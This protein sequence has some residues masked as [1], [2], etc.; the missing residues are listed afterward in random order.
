ML[1]KVEGGKLA[2]PS[3]IFG[4]VHL[5][6]G[7]LA[8]LH[9]AV[10]TAFGEADV[11][12]T[13]IPMDAKSQ[14][15]GTMK[16]LRKD[17]KKLSDS[18]GPD[19]S[20]QFDAELSQINPQLDST[21]FQLLKT[22]VAAISLELIEAQMKGETAMDQ[23]LWQRAEKEGKKTDAIETLDSQLGVF[24]S[25]N[26]EEQ[27]EFLAE[28]LKMAREDREAGKDSTQELVDI[29]IKGDA[30][31]LKKEMDRQM[32]IMAKGEHKELGERLMKKI[33][34]DRD[35]TM[36]ESIAKKL[37]KNP[38]ECHFFA[39]GAAHFAGPTSIRSHLEKQGYRITRI[40]K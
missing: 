7:P 1:W 32:E 26:E 21:P 22:W 12:Y 27:V 5:G 11:V 34:T 10:D 15:D 28:S 31:L 35:K 30:D 20:K 39:A 33:L 29:Y 18:I 19:L 37:A 14:L 25:F 13:E 3:Y 9:P 16:T 23:K 24:D 17:G 36:S 8:K 38:G 40:E 4:T 6:S 2:K